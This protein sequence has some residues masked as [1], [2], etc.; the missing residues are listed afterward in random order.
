MENESLPKPVQ[1]L[2]SLVGRQA[3]RRAAELRQAREIAEGIGLPATDQY[4]IRSALHHRE[5]E[6][7]GNPPV[8]GEAM[9]EQ[10]GQSNT[11]P[12]SADESTK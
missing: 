11:G 2:A 10:S 6:G 3:R 4:A 12:E 8:N 5:P 1:G 7:V 9:P